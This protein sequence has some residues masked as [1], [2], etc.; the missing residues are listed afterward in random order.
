MC[1]GCGLGLGKAG[2]G[3]GGMREG[4][5]T[6]SGMWVVRERVLY[7]ECMDVLELGE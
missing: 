4:M 7:G 5:D 6:G 1:P 2:D 3:V